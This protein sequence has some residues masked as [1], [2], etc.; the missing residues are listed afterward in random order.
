LSQ[1]I[2]YFQKGNIEPQSLRQLKYHTFA[3]AK[4]EQ[5][6]KEFY[7]YDGASIWNSLP[8]HIRA[9]KSLS[10]FKEKLLPIAYKT[11]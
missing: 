10:S 3:K 5:Y 1:R 4:Y 6:E 2:I 9:S 7:V 8:E 11:T